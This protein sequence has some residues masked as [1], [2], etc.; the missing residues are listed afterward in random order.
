MARSLRDL[1]QKIRGVKSTRQ[2]TKAMELVA[3]SKMRRAVQNSQMLRRYAWTAWNILQRIADIYPETHPYLQK[4]PVNKILCVLFSTDRGLAGSLNAQ[5]FRTTLQYI[6]GVQTLPKFEQLDFVAIGKK[7]QQFLAR[8]GQRIIAAFSGLSNHPTFRDTYAISRLVT[9]AFLKEEYDQVVLLYPDCISALQQLPTAKVLLPLS[10]SDLRSMLESIVPQRSS[11]K[12][13][14][15][16]AKHV[17]E[18]LFEPSQKEVLK[19]IIPQLTE[20]QIYQAIL[21]TAASEHSARMVAMRNATENAS[22]IIDDL[23][24]TYNKTRQANITAELAELSASKAALE[25]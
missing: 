14:E 11:Q 17:G 4:R 21:E 5:L 16:D 19:V 12:L 10:Q 9:D 13:S 6:A 20:V 8:Q 23:T 22:E 15:P 3:A 24:L 1:R 2:V 18:Y 7:G 25:A